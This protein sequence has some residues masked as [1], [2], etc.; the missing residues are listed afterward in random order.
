MSGGS[1][2]R[3]WPLSRGDYPKQ[4][5][6]MN[7]PYSL[8][9]EAVLRL[10]KEPHFAPPI[11]TCAETHRFIIAEQM[12]SL[13]IQPAAIL[14]EPVARSTAAVAALACQWLIQNSKDPNPLFLLMP[15]DHAI[16]NASAF[17]KACLEAADA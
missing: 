15:T 17:V 13:D 11:I 9:Q 5:L 16:G 6:R 7:G 10:K 1:G 4:F 12:R 2:S 8:L 3:L 14:L